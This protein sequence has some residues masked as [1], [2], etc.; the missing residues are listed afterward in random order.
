MGEIILAHHQ[1]TGRVHIDPMDDPRAHDSVDA[2]ELI[3]AMVYQRIDQS[4]R[5]MPCR[6]MD[7]HPLRLID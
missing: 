3:L 7:N 5:I 1:H 6:R 2:G 4:P